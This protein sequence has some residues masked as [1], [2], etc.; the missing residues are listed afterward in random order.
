MT[1]QGLYRL[2]PIS[3]R[4]VAPIA[5]WL[6]RRGAH[7]DLVTLSAV[8]VAI[9]GGFSLAASPQAPWLLLLVPVLAAIRLGLNLLDGMVA[10]QSGRAH[11]MGEMWNE[12]GD[13]VADA[14]FIGGLAWVPAVGPFL[15]SAAVVAALLASYVG[16]TSRA[17]GARRQY[18]GVMSK[19]GR[20]AT[21]A[22]A[23][24]LAFFTGWD[25][26]LTIAAGVIAVGAV[27]TLG[28]RVLDARREL[29]PRA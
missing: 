9:V 6:V 24:P 21:L 15:G 18:G 20:M 3:Q 28:Q 2:K 7:P 8:P 11:P 22:I 13:R 14:S 25:G 4:L 16:I 17:A 12:L 10:R 1:P 27:V 5:G 29:E 23:A 19:P 26:W